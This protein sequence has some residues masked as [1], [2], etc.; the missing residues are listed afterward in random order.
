MFSMFIGQNVEHP[1]K[2]VEHPVWAKT[3]Q[4]G[5]IVKLELEAKT[6]YLCLQLP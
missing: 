4:F 1:G 6:D 3:A 5:C 2:D